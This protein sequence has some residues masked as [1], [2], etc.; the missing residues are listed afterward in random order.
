MIDNIYFKKLLKYENKYFNTDDYD[1]KQFYKNKINLILKKINDYN[2]SF[3]SQEQTKIVNSSKKNMLV[4]AINDK[5]KGTGNS[6]QHY[7]YIKS[8]SYYDMYK[9]YC[10]KNRDFYNYNDFFNVILKKFLSSENIVDIYDTYDNIFM[11]KCIF[12]YTYLDYKFKLAIFQYFFAEYKSYSENYYNKKDN[13]KKDEYKNTKNTY[14]DD[15][16]SKAL[17]SL[18]INEPLENLTQAIVNKQFRQLSLMYHPDKPGGSI[19]RQQELAD[20]RDKVIEALRNL[21]K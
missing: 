19:L 20:A 18:K 3:L 5:F 6:N 1:E 17:K 9:I 16:I 13:N 4:V 12:T 21:G 11:E 14:Y 7:A 8:I 2:L 10:S 15:K